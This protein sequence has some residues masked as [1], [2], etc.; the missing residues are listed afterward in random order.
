MVHFDA[1]VSIGMEVTVCDSSRDDA[2]V[3]FGCTTA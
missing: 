2:Y 1:L 3:A